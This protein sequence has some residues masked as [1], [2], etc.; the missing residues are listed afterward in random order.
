MKKRNIST[1]RTYRIRNN[2]K[3]ISNSTNSSEDDKT[4]LN[5]L[6]LHLPQLMVN[7]YMFR[8]EFQ[9]RM[10]RKVTMCLRYILYFC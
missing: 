5:N 8:T 10:L 1:K 2:F 3:A 4:G 7:C 6:S 9:C